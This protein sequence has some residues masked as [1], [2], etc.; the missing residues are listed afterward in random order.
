MNGR[1]DTVQS[2]MFSIGAFQWG[3]D[4]ISDLIREWVI[5]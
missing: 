3:A 1:R 5:L 2:C 4:R